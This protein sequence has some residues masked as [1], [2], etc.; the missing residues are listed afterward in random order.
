MNIHNELSVKRLEIC[1]SC[2]FLSSFG[3]CAKCGCFVNI[4]VMFKATACPVNKWSA[5]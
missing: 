3:Q 5:V 1:K 4:K 2:E